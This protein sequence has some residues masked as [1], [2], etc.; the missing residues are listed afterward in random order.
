MCG[1]VCCL[2]HVVCVA[3]PVAH[4]PSPWLEV[5]VCG[6]CKAD[7]NQ[8]QSVSQS[9]CCQLSANTGLPPQ[10]PFPRDQVEFGPRP[11]LQEVGWWLQAIV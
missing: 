8:L 9:N 1:C 11:A 2:G 4:P 5:G 10:P 3:V 6:C 7:A